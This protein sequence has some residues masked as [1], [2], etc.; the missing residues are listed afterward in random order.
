MANNGLYQQQCTDLFIGLWLR[1]SDVVPF[2]ADT[3][4]AVQA[5][6]CGFLEWH[7]LLIAACLQS[8]QSHF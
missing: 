2:T 8:Q 7:S 6:M 4:A 5:M 3:S 1:D